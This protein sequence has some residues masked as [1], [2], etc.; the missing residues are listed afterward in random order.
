VTPLIA[1]LKILR[2]KNKHIHK[3]SEEDAEYKSRLSD[4]HVRTAPK[5]VN[6]ILSMGGIYVKIGQFMST[7]GSGILNDSYVKALRPLQ[8]GVP[9]REYEDIKRIIEDSTGKK[10]EDMFVSFEERPIGAAS[11]AQAHRAVLRTSNNEEGGGGGGGEVIVKVQYPEVADL[12]NADLNNLETL[13]KYLAPDNMDLINNLR[14]RHENELDF[15][16]EASNLRECTENMQR[17]N[18]EPQLVRIPRVRNE[19]GLCTQHVLVM[20]YLK[21]VSMADAIGLEQDKVGR[22]LGY[23]DRDGLKSALSKKMREHFENGGDGT[24]SGSATDFF[25]EDGQDDGRKRKGASNNIM[26]QF[27]MGPTAARM[28]RSYANLKERVSNLLGNN[29]DHDGD[30]ITAI[31]HDNLSNVNLGRVLK[32]LIHVHGLQMLSDGVYNADPHPGN[33]LILPDGRLGLLDYGMVGRLSNQD[34]LR[35]VDTVLALS[36]NDKLTAAKMYNESGYKAT[37]RNGVSGGEKIQDVNVLHPI[38][39]LSLRSV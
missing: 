23:E 10:M 26:Q 37:W 29:S 30:G 32:T 24:E 15:R 11:I 34:R 36:K 8:D 5:A 3:L 1:E 38:C 22:A 7:I 19:T 6:L 25:L 4:F 14:S 31:N 39:H 9:P 18:M 16:I 2:F 33:V 27:M 17:Y 12:F 20:E 35:V 28:L 13:T 21:G